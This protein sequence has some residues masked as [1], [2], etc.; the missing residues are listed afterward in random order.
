[1]LINLINIKIFMLHRHFN[2]VNFLK[3]NNIFVNID[4]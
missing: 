1:M 2:S 4:N 3:N